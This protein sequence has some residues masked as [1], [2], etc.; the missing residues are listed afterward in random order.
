[1]NIFEI[2]GF[3]HSVARIALIIIIGFRQAVASG[4]ALSLDNQLLTVISTRDL[5]RQSRVIL[6]ATMATKRSY[7]PLAQIKGKMSYS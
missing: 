6:M 4:C 5:N 1:M 7:G 2:E 3:N